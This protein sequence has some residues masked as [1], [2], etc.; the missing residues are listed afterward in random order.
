MRYDRASSSGIYAIEQ[1]VDVAPLDEALNPPAFGD[2]P[3]YAGH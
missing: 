1:P 3:P 2:K